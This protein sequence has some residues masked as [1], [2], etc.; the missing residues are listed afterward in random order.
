MQAAPKIVILAISAA[1]KRAKIVE[2]DAFKRGCGATLADRGTVF[3]GNTVHFDRVEFVQ[4]FVLQQ[5]QSRNIV[6]RIA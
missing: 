2:L 6:K 3:G 4:A 5:R 1:E